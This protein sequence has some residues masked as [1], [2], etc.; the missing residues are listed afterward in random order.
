MY[1]TD[2]LT[3]TNIYGLT[4]PSLLPSGMC[5]ATRGRDLSAQLQGWMKF[6]S[7]LSPVHSDAEAYHSFRP[8]LS[9]RQDSSGVT[10]NLQK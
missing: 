3:N 2:L 9:A 5:T 7:V 8:W 1:F 4:V 6:V 10:C